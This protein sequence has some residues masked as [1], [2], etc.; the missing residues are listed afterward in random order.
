MTDG[1]QQPYI[2]LTE[3]VVDALPQDPKILE[4]ML[5]AGY[6]YHP[7]LPLQISNIM[8]DNQ[9]PSNPALPPIRYTCCE[10]GCFAECLDEQD[11][12]PCWGDISCIDSTFYE[13]F[14]DELITTAC[15][16]HYWCYPSYDWSKYTKP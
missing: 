13:E 15:E 9:P 14:D 4:Q 8:L 10:T 2:S 11:Q 1:Y 16:G 5:E 3:H 6:I 12:Y 7:Y